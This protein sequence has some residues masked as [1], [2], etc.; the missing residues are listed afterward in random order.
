MRDARCQLAQRTQLVGARRTLALLFLLGDIVRDAKHPSRLAIDDNWRGV[1][2]RK[3]NCAV[4]RYVARF[5]A[6]RLTVEGFRETFTAHLTIL[7]VRAFEKTVA[8]DF[9]QLEE[10]RQMRR[11]RFAE[12]LDGQ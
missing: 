8:N 3:S 2:G 9:L 11:E 7:F 1:D 4:A 12:A 10:D 5:K 6:L